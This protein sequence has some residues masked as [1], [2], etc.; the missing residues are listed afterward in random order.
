MSPAPTVY[1]A[2]AVHTVDP[3]LPQATAVLVT[4]DR[5]R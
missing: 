2:R 5:A 1:L 3:A 4:G